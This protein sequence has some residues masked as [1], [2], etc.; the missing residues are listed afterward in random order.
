MSIKT[1]LRVIPRAEHPISRAQINP[2]ALK[3]L[4]RL[5]QAGYESHLVGG[6]VRDLMLGREPKDFDVV[7]NALPEEI[8]ELF[9]NARL[10]GRR[11]RLAH[12]RF[13]RDIIEVATYRA[14]PSEGEDDIE[15]SESGRI[16]RDNVYGNQEEDA[17]RRDF[18]VNALYYDIAD[19]S[20]KDYVGGAEDLQQGLIRIIGDPETRYREDPVRM[21]RAVRFAAKLGLLIEKTTAEPIARLAPLLREVPSAR[22]FEEVLKLFHGGAALNTFEQLRHYHLFESLFPQ[23]E[24]ALAEEPDG[25]PAMLVPLGLKSTDERINSGKSVN[26][27]FLFA[28]MLWAPMRKHMQQLLAGGRS[29]A[30]AMR[31]AA[32]E[33][34]GDQTDSTSI[35]RRFTTIVRDIWFMQ[36]RFERRTGKRAYRVLAHERFRAAYDFMCLRGQAGETDPA[37]CQWWTEF[38][39]T[40]Q[41]GQ[42]ALLAAVG[43]EANRSGKRRRRRRRRPES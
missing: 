8:G 43:D 19:F 5:K 18:T 12:V 2:N 30:D 16:L 22:L 21:L 28:V 20:V 34:L 25:F 37:L 31:L 15:R 42:A 4:N 32:S 6:C 9:R 38:Q 24:G 39:E 17:V 36:S 13:G 41:P 35:P 40:D 3:V 11:F 26:P 33:I 29:E 27:A 10:V 23:T 1:Q 14:L 7:T